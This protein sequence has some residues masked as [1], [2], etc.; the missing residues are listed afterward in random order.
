MTACRPSPMPRRAGPLPPYTGYAIACSSC[1]EY[2]YSR[3]DCG[4]AA[5]YMKGESKSRIRTQRRAANSIEYAR[6]AL[7]FVLRRLPRVAIN[8]NMIDAYPSLLA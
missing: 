3:R 5:G 4:G 7:P 8:V 1:S 2:G 6:E